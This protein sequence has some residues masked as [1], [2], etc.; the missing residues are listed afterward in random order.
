MKVL[1]AFALLMQAARPAPAL[2]P[3][4]YPQHKKLADN[5]YVWSDVHPTGL[6]T[7]NDLIVITADGVLVADGQ[8]DA[9]TTQKMV[10]GIRKL[11]SLPMRYVVVCSEHGDHAGGNTAFPADAVF[12]SSPFSKE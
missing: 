6:Y 5:V 9:A 8:K 3:A 11:T 2:N 7:T 12:I 10:D 4:D 1:L